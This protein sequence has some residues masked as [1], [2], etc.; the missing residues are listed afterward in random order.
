M[1]VKGVL[2]CK[3]SPYP[4]KSLLSNQATK[5]LFLKNRLKN[6]NFYIG[7]SMGCWLRFCVFS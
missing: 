5:A 7:F 2:K 1:G 4:L 3:I 6:I